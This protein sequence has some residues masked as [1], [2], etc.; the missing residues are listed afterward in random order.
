MERDATK[1]KV[2]SYDVVVVGA[3]ISGCVIAERCAN[4]LDQRVLIIE[5][6]DHIGGNCYDFLN[7]GGVLVPKYGPHFFHTNDEK[8]WSYVNQFSD[9]TPYEHRVLS[10]VDGELVPIPVNITTVNRIFGLDMKT[11]P[12]MREWLAQNVLK[13][14]NPKNSEESALARVG[15]ILYEKMFKNY[16]KK[17]WD[18]WPADLDAEVMNRIPVRTNFDDRYFSDIHQAMPKDG[19]TK[20]FERMLGNENIEVRLATDWEEAKRSVSN[21]KTLFFTGPID[22]FF[23]Y[24]FNGKLQYRSLRFEF[25]TLNV[26]YFQKTAQ[27]N[28]PSLEVPYTRITEPKHATGQKIGKTTI[29]KEYSTW[30][31][32]PY[33]PVPTE[34]NKKVY[35]GY[36]KE[37]EKLES[38]GIYFVGRLANYK[39]FNMDQAFGNALNLFNKIFHKE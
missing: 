27:T 34:Q 6:R 31:G 21:F 12:E 37:A 4:I 16:T 17:Q 38:Q 19:Y 18:M 13:I 8:V 26:D 29:I 3:G 39:Y 20:M 10:S 5:K 2:Q 22:Q 11:E 32:E 23:Q 28:Y 25:E 30:E 9:W 36:Q 7:E 1:S 35:A 15:R 14:E 33:Y 24:K